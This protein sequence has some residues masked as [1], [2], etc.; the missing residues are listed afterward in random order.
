VQSNE[1]AQASD[2][3]EGRDE[4]PPAGSD[5]EMSALGA[6]G[7]EPSAAGERLL[8]DARSP[9][10]ADAP[11]DGAQQNGALAAIVGEA[12]GIDGIEVP[13]HTTRGFSFRK[14]WAFMGPG[15]LVSIAYIDPGNFAVDLQ[16]GAELKYMLV[17][18]LLVATVLSLVLQSLSSRLG[19]VTGRNLA[20]MCRDAL[21]TRAAYCLWVVA[22]ITVIASDIPEVIGTAIALKLLFG[23]ELWIGVLVTSVSVLVFLGLS[24]WGVRKIELFIAMLLGVVWVCFLVEFGLSAPSPGS[25]FAGFLPNMSR[26]G[27]YPAVALVG[28]VVMP[29]NLFLH[30]AL[31]QSRRIRRTAYH[32][33]DACLYNNV[34][35]AIALAI[36]FTINVTI[37]SVAATSLTP[38]SAEV[39]LIKIPHLLRNTLGPAAGTLFA[40]ALLASG[41]SSTMTGTYAGQFVMEGFLRI[42]IP[43]WARAILTRSTAIVPSLLAALLAG[44][45]GSQSLIVLSQ[46]VLSMM[47]PFALIPLLR[48]TSHEPLMGEFATKRFVRLFA[49]LLGAVLLV[50]N[51]GLV[52][53]TVLPLL[54][55]GS[56]V[57]RGFSIFFT[58]VISLVYLWAL[59]FLLRFPIPVDVCHRFHPVVRSESTY[60]MNSQ[61]LKD[62]PLPE[63]PLNGKHAVGADADI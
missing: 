60:N 18:V 5:T 31:V 24:Y 50:A 32:L 43:K 48:F 10:D 29:H 42:F 28:S 58:V 25:L 63:P 37:I 41:Q 38:E 57:V 19:I 13:E 8:A 23:L 40:V 52:F 51:V 15:F 54:E 30:S 34:E 22:E 56:A 20:Q 16:A 6:A 27:L 61:A 9:S 4:G 1:P 12:Y 11:G 7:D 59:H 35:S 14:L 46:V 55:G 33:N 2:L 26:N 39:G 49:S 21:P 36:S 17:W 62:A 47:L 3:G 45:K 44:E 53:V